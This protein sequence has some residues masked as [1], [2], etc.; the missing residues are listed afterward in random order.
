MSSSGNAPSG[1]ARR[2]RA[3]RLAGASHDPRLAAPG[4][5]G[6]AFRPLTVTQIDRI[7][8]AALDVLE[9]V[10]IGEPI[11]EILAVAL[12][13]GCT[14]DGQ[15]RL[16]FPRG[17]VD[18]V[19]GSACREYVR[20][21][22]DPALDQ[23][24]SGERVYFATSGEAVTILDYE[25]HTFRPS[26]LVDLYD[27]ARLVDR[28]ENIHGYGQPFVATE[29]SQDLIVHDLNVAYAALAGTQKPFALSTS[30][31]AHIPPLLA[32]FDL[33]AG[34]EG[35]FLERP[36]A[37][38][39][40]CPIVS[41]LRFGRENAEVLVEVARLGLVADIAVAPQAGATAPA[42]LA[43]TLVQCLAETLAC[44]CVVNFVRPGVPFDFGMW[45][46]VSDL[47]TG[48]FTGGGGEQALLMAASA[49]IANHLGLVSS[50]A[51]GMTDA[52]T[53]DAQA[54]YEKGVSVTAAALAGGN[55]LSSYPGMVGSLMGQSFE[56]LVI[57]NDMLGAV[58][59]VVRGI[60]VSDET[61]SV[62]VIESV[63]AGVG[64][65]LGSEQ[66]LG[67]MRSEFVYPAVA[68]RSTPGAWEEDGSRTAYERAHGRVQELLASHYPA[69][70]EPAV[71]A[72]IRE[73]FPIRLAPA[74][75]RPGNGRF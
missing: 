2:G 38:I 40:G 71:D 11:P 30:T 53:M 13:R 35:R 20:Y 60:E 68:D 74:D 73:R 3:A 41:P 24:I 4:Y 75:M 58:Q 43:G 19:V 52:K 69:Y 39:G 66:T 33:V 59:R 12:P 27:A 50:V 44:L 70:L 28:L 9:R 36:F 16:R 42:A 25:T 31:A 55:L 8:E 65:Y 18:K 56:G 26:T 51:A 72:A 17:L 63:V 37:S 5:T 61:L 47:R 15:G 45:P 10:G 14:V 46:F 1:S 64:H 34:G 6:G 54:G 29:H 22:V 57:D 23:E 67:L 32:L 49:Q 7:Y 62:D 48:A 21:G